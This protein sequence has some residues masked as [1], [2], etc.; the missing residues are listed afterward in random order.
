MKYTQKYKFPQWDPADKI[1]LS[2]FNNFAAGVESALSKIV[3]IHN[4]RIFM[5]WQY[6]TGGESLSVP[7]EFVPWMTLICGNQQW[8]LAGNKTI[9]P[10]AGSKE[11]LAANIHFAWRADDLLIRHRGTGALP[12][13]SD[14][15]QLYYIL[16]ITPWEV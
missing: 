8:L 10:L 13:F 3:K 1:L 12:Y 6:G 16:G 14:S 5:T 7:Y 9:D 11:A 2:D 15:S 4:A